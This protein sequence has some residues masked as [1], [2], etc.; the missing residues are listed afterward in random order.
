MKENIELT[1]LQAQFNALRNLFLGCMVQFWTPQERW[2][3]K[4]ILW[5][6]ERDILGEVC[7]HKPGTPEG[8]MIDR[9]RFQLQVMMD[10]AYIQGHLGECDIIRYIDPESLKIANDVADDYEELMLPK[11]EKYL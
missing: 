7:K 3:Y 6:S 8:D 10:V 5:K 2:R 9:R 4:F 1:I 11:I